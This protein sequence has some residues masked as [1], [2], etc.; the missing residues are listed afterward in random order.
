MLFDEHR[1][2]RFTQ[3]IIILA[4]E[5]LDKLYVLENL[6]TIVD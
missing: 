5:N 3:L 4:C 6:Q 2:K 1:R